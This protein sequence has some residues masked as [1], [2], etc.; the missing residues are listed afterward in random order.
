MPMNNPIRYRQQ[1]LHAASDLT[2]RGAQRLPERARRSAAG[3]RTGALDARTRELVALGAA[4]SLRCDGCVS[5][6]A[7]AAR[8]FGASRE[9]IAE[10][11]GAA[12]AVTADAALA[13]PQH[14]PDA[15]GASGASG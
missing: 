15:P 7:A 3:E 14:V 10:A 6:H 8:R 12:I 4:V 2:A 1:L 5:V 11:L 13:D 9:Q